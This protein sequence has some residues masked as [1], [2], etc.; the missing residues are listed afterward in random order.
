MEEWSRERSGHGSI[1]IEALVQRVVLLQGPVMRDFSFDW[2]ETCVCCSSKM[3]SGCYLSADHHSVA[4]LMIKTVG[5]RREADESAVGKL[6]SW[7]RIAYQA[8]GHHASNSSDI[9]TLV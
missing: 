1:V 5:C 4:T 7:R 9:V 2:I 3:R 8:S 6:E